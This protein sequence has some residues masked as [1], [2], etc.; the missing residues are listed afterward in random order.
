MANSQEKCELASWM[1][2][3]P[4]SLQY[5]TEEHRRKLSGVLKKMQKQAR[6]MCF[7]PKLEVLIWGTAE[8]QPLEDTIHRE[9]GATPKYFQAE[10]FFGNLQLAWKVHCKHT[11]INHPAACLHCFR[12]N[13]KWDWPKR[14]NTAFD[15]QTQSKLRNPW[16]GAF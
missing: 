11:R 2:I 6:K 16:I 7:P 10:I 5:V 14:Q 15:Y 4:S 12:E 1:L 3:W 8:M 13:L 9:Y